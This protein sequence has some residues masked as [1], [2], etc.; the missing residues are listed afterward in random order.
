MR[1]THLFT[2]MLAA[3]ALAACGAA[4][5]TDQ[6]YHETDD[7][8]TADLGVDF[9]PEGEPL[10]SAAV[11]LVRAGETFTGGFDVA[12]T[13]PD[14]P[15]VTSETDVTIDSAA[16]SGAAETALTLDERAMSL[17]GSW[18]DEPSVEGCYAGPETPGTICATVIPGGDGEPAQ[19]CGSL[20]GGPRLCWPFAPGGAA[21]D[22]PPA[23]AEPSAVQGGDDAG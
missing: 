1:S 17:D 9:H 10:G 16:A 12:V 21:A 2:T 22:T 4:T 11:D 18:G 20:N 5:I 7:G 14:G 8:W 6:S 23:G 13:P 19:V 3:L 15:N